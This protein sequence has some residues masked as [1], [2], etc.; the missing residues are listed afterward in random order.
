LFWGADNF[1]IGASE[2]LALQILGQERFASLDLIAVRYRAR[3]VWQ[4]RYLIST[5][6][7]GCATDL[8]VVPLSDDTEPTGTA[9]IQSRHRR[10]SPAGNRRRAGW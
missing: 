4:E 3:Q 7:F 6:D 1:A 10:P 2:T 9:G 8:L 5:S